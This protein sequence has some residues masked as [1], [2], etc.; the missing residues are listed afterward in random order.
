MLARELRTAEHREY[1]AS[2]RGT[3]H[4]NVVA[5]GNILVAS[6]PDVLSDA[7]GSASSPVDLST[8]WTSVMREGAAIEDVALEFGMPVGTALLRAAAGKWR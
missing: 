4:R 7:M 5:P 2:G 8:L 6:A 1:G 3:V